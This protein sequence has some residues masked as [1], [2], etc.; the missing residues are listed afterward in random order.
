[1]SIFPKGSSKPTT[2]NLKS[3]VS[4][5]VID[6]S[7]DTIVQFEDE[8]AVILAV[9]AAIKKDK[10]T[11]L[12]IRGR[13]LDLAPQRLYTLPGREA[14]IAGSTAAR[15]EAL[16]AL[17][18]RIESEA[19]ALNVSELWSFVQ[20][21]V[22]TYSVAELCKSYFGS[23]TL[24]KH[25]GLRIALIRERLHF[26]RDKDLFEPRVAAV[27]EDLKCAEEAK[28]HKAQV[29]EATIDFLAK[30]KHDSTLPIP[31]EIRD[32]IQLLEEVA[33][34]IQHTEPARQKEGKELVHL[35]MQLLKLPEDMTLEKQAFEILLTIRHFERDTN[36][37]FIRHRIPVQHEARAVLEGESLVIPREIADF[38]EHERSF[39]EDLTRLRA[40]TIDD[41]STQD[42][43]DAI[44]LEQTQD[45][46]QLGIHITDVAWAVLPETYLDFAARRRATSIYSADQTVNMLPSE[47]SESKL[48]LKQGAVRPALSVILSLDRSF[49]VLSSRITPAFIKA[50]ER[51]SYDQVD[52]LLEQGLL[53]QGDSTL[54]L[55]HDIA[56]ACEERRIRK[57]ATRVHKRE[58]VP[59][60]EEDGSI[61]LLEIEEDGP[62]RMLV[63]EMMVLANSIMAQFAAT[64]GIP[65]LFRGQERAEGA[66]EGAKDGAKD[67]ATEELVPE[68]PAKDF[69]ARTKLKKSSTSCEPRSHAGLGLDAYIQATS[70]I[71]RYMDLCHQR[72]FIS[73]F[74]TSK[75]WVT[76]PE[77]ELIAKEV[78][79]HLQAATVASRETRRYWLL[80]YL[81]QRERGKA[82]AGTV[83]RL[84]LKTPLIE[85]DEIYIT[86][87][88]RVPK[89]TKLGDHV[90]LKISAIDP[91]T[92]YVRLEAV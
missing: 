70:P 34:G 49:E 74:R 21:D 9:V 80:R 84:D 4:D 79:G 18:G 60:K 22:R 89:G 24:E 39:R 66:K 82:I 44:S 13:E 19:D 69:S 57:G 59:F 11:I 62:A 12:T 52:H 56:A 81:E 50:A 86:L 35:A 90:S 43:D 91:H 38:P 46:Y 45:G 29:R 6:T 36:L 72:Q 25:A 3:Q 31:F 63:S 16:K 87:F 26:K 68:G 88:A 14:S 65:V 20:D 47:L 55:L 53:E 23:D 7:V 40:I 54:L 17:Q 28:R 42:M 67:G 61:R 73:F 85:L 48:S 83:V 77:F 10:R 92:E 27:V 41:V 1:M 30:R 76:R 64:H 2:Q 78:E 75:P 5:S 32:N 8:G 58:V 33:A 51:Y 15:I 71:R 37:S